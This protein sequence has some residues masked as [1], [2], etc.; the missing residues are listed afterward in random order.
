MNLASF[1]ADKC[2]EYFLKGD[3]GHF[4]QNS[5]RNSAPRLP[6]LPPWS[7]EPNV[8]HTLCNG[9]GNCVTACTNKII[10]LG[11][12]GFPEV[13]FFNS[14]CTFCGD[15]A[16]SCSTG[17][18]HFDQECPPWDVCAFVNENCL[19]RN[20]ILCCICAE[21]CER[22]AIILPKTL[23]K[24]GVPEIQAA[25]CDGCGACYGTCPTEAIIFKKKTDQVRS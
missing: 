14:S 2:I 6:L 25:K 16:Q 12:D 20:R 24:G 19:L 15:C 18:L 22:E 1:F 9:C 11:K 7:S 17:A 23:H 4:R 13:D 5:V 10:V 21:Q 3:S 8:F